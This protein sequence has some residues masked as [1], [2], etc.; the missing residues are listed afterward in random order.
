MKIKISKLSLLL[1]GVFGA[2]TLL[3][4]LAFHSLHNAAYSFL[5]GASLLLADVRRR[6][7][8]ELPLSV[9]H[10]TQFAVSLGLMVLAFVVMVAGWF[11]YK[12]DSLV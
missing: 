4:L 9:T 2:I 6:E 5:I 3:H 8:G 7:T 10:R 12:L 1:A 11:G